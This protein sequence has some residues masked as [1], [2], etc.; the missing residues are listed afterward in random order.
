MG[1]E[2]AASGCRRRRGA[3]RVDVRDTAIGIAPE[4][5]PRLFEKFYQVNP[6]MTRTHG[7]AGLGLSISKMLVEAHGGSI[8]VKSQV[9]L[10]STFWFT[11]PQQ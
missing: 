3:L 9:G 5:L 8:G 1:V 7:G 11:L 6:S 2:C 4:H 10:G